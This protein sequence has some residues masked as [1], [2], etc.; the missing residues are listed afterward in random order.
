MKFITTPV[1]IPLMGHGL[2]SCGNLAHNPRVKGT[3]AADPIT[4]ND[5]KIYGVFTAIDPDDKAYPSEWA[6]TYRIDVDRLKCAVAPDYS[7]IF[8]EL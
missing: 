2:E 3:F 8:A 1:T 4:G 6:G 5:G 7:S